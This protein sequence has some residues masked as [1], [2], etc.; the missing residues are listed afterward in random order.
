MNAAAASKRIA[1]NLVKIRQARN[2]SQRKLAE[3]LTGAGTT[4]V[5]QPQVSDMERGRNPRITVETLERLANVLDV[6]VAELLR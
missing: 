5:R 4:T 6:S 3:M 1:T 2:I